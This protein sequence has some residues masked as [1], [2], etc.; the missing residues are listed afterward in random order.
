MYNVDQ[1]THN[2]DSNQGRSTRSGQE[3]NTALSSH[4]RS[5]SPK[6]E[7]NQVGNTQNLP[8]SGHGQTDQQRSNAAYHRSEE[9]TAPDAESKQGGGKHDFSSQSD[10]GRSNAAQS[11]CAPNAEG[12]STLPRPAVAKYD[13]DVER[14]QDQGLGRGVDATDPKPWVNKGNFQVRK[15]TFDNIISTDEG[16]LYHDFVNDVES[17]QTFQT[18]LSASVPVDQLV[19]LG[20]DSELSHVYSVSQKSIGKKVLTRTISF[21]P[22]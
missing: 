18:S 12:G 13:H 5:S 6:S 15:I 2:A 11:T 16:N 3:S 8:A 14:F 1:I 20:I 4:N 17:I 21:R 7:S 22:I 19:S 9:S 10:Q